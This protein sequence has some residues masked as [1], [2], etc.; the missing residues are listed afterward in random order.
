MVLEEYEIAKIGL[1][2]GR[3]ATSAINGIRLAIVNNNKPVQWKPRIFAQ[4]RR[5]ASAILRSIRGCFTS[6]TRV[7]SGD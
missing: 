5:V 3:F 7:T 1:N 4:L 6:S 2:G